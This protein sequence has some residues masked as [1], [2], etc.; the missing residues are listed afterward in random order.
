MKNKCKN[1]FLP[2]F[3]VV[4]LL[5]ITSLVFP[6][7][8]LAQTT[9]GGTPC[10]CPPAAD[11]PVVIVTDNSG[12]GTG[13]VTWSCD[14][15]Y[16]LQEYVFVN[17]GDTLTI[18]PGAIIKGAPGQGFS[19]T[20]FSVGNITEQ[21][22][23]YTTYP[24]SLVIS[25]GAVLIADGT[26]DCA[27]TFTYEADPLDGSIGV[28][29]KG[30]WGGL[31]ICGASAT[32]TLYYDMTGF[33]SQSLG[34]G[35]GTDL[36]EG[37]IDPTG[38]FRHV[39]GGNTDP[40]GSSGILRYASFRHGSTS[41]GYHQNL[42]TN[43][44]NNGDETNLLQ[45]CAVGSGTQID[46]IEVVSSADDGL[47]IMG[48][49]VELKYIA[50]GFNAEDG[51]EFDHGWGGKIQYLFIITDSSEV[52]GD[53]LGISNALD[54]EGD[55]WEQSNVDISFMPYTNPTIINA[56]FI[57]PKSQSGLRLHN[58]GATRMSNN[59]FVGFGQGIDFE[60]Y[61]PCDAWELFLFDEYALINNHFWDCGDSTS[62]YD[63]ILYDGNLGYGPSAIAGDFVAN[64]N[65]AIDPMF[66]Y[67]LAIDPLTGM[68]NDP[69][70]LEPGNGVVPA[71]EFISPD[72]W[73]DQAMYFGA[74][75]PGGENWLTCWSYLEQVG[76]FTVGDS[77]G[78]VSVP[79]CIYNSACNFNIDATIDDGTCIFDGCSGCTD[80]TACN[81]DSVAII[82]DCTCF[83]PAAGYDCMGVCI[84]DTDMD[85]V[86]DGDEI[87]GCQ[88]I[89]ACD[90]S[91]SATDPGACD[92]SCNGCTYDA[93]TN[94][95]VTAT[96]DDG[97]CIFP[98]AS[99]CPEDIN[100]DGYV[101]TVDLLDLL[102]AYGMICTP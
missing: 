8:T 94:F 95:D 73:F 69:V 14:Y 93:A 91:S 11:R 98:I 46:H 25:R 12:Q 7:F 22:I 81:Y 65:I 87:S 77:V 86:C 37:V 38:A 30:E 63:M 33:P 23:T 4:I 92:Y 67:S 52:V 99:L 42:S 78:V 16:V 102:S 53:N 51:V 88:D 79:G 29:I 15:I 18:E 21:T 54:I 59:I 44:S 3:M 49:S 74:F 75:E 40:T 34:L 101:T 76:L 70:F 28:D 56:T 24:A 13:T 6:L 19:E 100:N 90:F 1:R 41:L 71:L 9:G 36:A 61:D 97:T 35:T 20:I 62:V 60:D 55:D 58:G 32:N 83:Y 43:E 26:P 10:S 89:D 17:P 64:N 96:L 45:L 39:Y 80:S 31:I 68:V 72:P 50:A 85:G 47:Q 82:S 84:Q 57:G 27:I 66:D 5:V 48:G 2:P